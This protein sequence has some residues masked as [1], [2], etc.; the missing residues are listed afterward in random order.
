MT[1]SVEEKLRRLWKLS[2]R[3]MLYYYDGT[4]IVEGVVDRSGNPW[5]ARWPDLHETLDHAIQC[6]ERLGEP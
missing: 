2:P 3:A 1:K 6:A 4:Y 5:T